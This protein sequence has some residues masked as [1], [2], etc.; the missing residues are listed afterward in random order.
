MIINRYYFELLGNYIVI[1]CVN[2]D[3]VNDRETLLRRVF[4]PFTSR[5]ITDV[6]DVNGTFDT[7]N[8]MLLLENTALISVNRYCEEI[9]SDGRLVSDLEPQRIGQQMAEFFW[10]S[11]LMDFD[12]LIGYVSEYTGCTMIMAPVPKRIIDGEIKTQTV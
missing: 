3:S 5:I 1:Y 6:T 10:L 9:L 4:A 11:E 7:N 8:L 12:S 2:Y